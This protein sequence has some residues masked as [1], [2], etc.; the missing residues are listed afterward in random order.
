MQIIPDPLVVALQLVPFLV[1]LGALWFI[2]FKP[3]MEYLDDR[4]KARVGGRE[5]A[6]QLQLRIDEKMADY[7]ARLAKARDEALDIRA[8]ARAKASAAADVKVAAARK[9][10]D[11]QIE[12]ALSDIDAERKAA[13]ESIAATSRTIAADIAG[14]IAGRDLQAG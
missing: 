10:A 2:I 5:E 1:T 3:M 12:A 4:E 13:A 14:R 11:A 6:E 9:A 8:A 7:E